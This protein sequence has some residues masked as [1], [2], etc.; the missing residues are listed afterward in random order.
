MTKKRYEKHAGEAGAQRA[1]PASAAAVTE[2]RGSSVSFISYI[3]YNLHKIRYIRV[4]RCSVTELD[5]MIAEAE[6]IAESQENLAKRSRDLLVNLMGFRAG[7]GG[8]GDVQYVRED[9]RLTEA[10]VRFC[11]ESF[12]LGLGP[13]EIARKLG[14]TVPA[15]VTRRQRWMRAKRLARSAGK[16]S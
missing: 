16:A 1:T 2:P 15:I 8:S 6:K 12:E 13:S 11:K 4:R 10:G 5:R 14:V 3:I 9:G 7:L